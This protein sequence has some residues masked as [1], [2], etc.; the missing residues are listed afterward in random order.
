VSV[1]EL[2]AAAAEDD[3]KCE[4][5]FYVGEWHLVKGGVASARKRFE[6]A[7][8]GCRPNMIERAM[9]EI[10]AKQ[11]PGERRASP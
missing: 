10:E 4:A 9:A 1:V 3:Q 8:G 7:F 2:D 11:L 5:N 6:Q